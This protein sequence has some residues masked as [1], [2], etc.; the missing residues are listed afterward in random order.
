MAIAPRK[1]TW[2]DRIREKIRTGDSE[3]AEELLAEMA[4]EAAEAGG[5]PNIT[6][7]MP[8]AAPAA[9]EKT[10]DEEGAASEPTLADLMA[11]INAIG[12][13]VGKLEAGEKAEAAANGAAT[14]DEETE[15]E[16]KKREEEEAAAGATGDSAALVQAFQ[17]AVSGAEII[18]PGIR[19]PTFDAKA[20][21]GATNTAIC[22]LRRNAMA[23]FL[24]TQPGATWGDSLGV[25]AAHLDGMTC[26]AIAGLFPVAVRDRKAGTQPGRH[27]GMTFP[28][29]D[30]AASYKPRSPAEIN[31]ANRKAFGFV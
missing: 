25:K 18:A 7:N 28:T 8:G 12:E 15:E 21:P 26:D 29:G 27:G 16:K 3:G 23:T 14:G 19:L 17:E 5:L 11:A 24:A 4:P 30:Q 20:R 22:T 13:R 1:K 10:G 2:L 31:A 9:N 6:I